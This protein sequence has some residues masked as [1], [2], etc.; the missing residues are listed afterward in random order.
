LVET[1]KGEG[2]FTVFAPTDEAFA[3][4]PEGT[5][6]ALLADPTGA[7]TEIL[8]YHVAPGQVM[9]A[10][11]AALDGQ[12]ITTVGGPS[13][14]VVITDGVVMLNDA[15]V[16]AT[17]IAAANGVIHVIDRVL[18]PSS[19]AAESTSSSAENAGG[20]SAESTA[21]EE[22]SADDAAGSTVESTATDTNAACTEVYH[23]QRGDTL[24][25]IA[26]R[27]GVN[28]QTLLQYNHIRNP[29]LIY[30]GQTICVP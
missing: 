22:Q 29:N 2:P 7:L 28:I 26:A 6:D 4:L 18:I 3:A 15:R 23:V 19:T 20:D 9:A 1:L 17:D 8:L 16:I 5:V 12:T 13:I 24:S 27:Y 25:G 30:R 10:D 21:G 14:A 11:V